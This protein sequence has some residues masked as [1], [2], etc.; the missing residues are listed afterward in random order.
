M[1][2][3]EQAS[4]KPIKTV[5]VLGAGS[6]GTALAIQLARAERPILLWGR[7]GQAIEAMARER[8][9]SRY[10]PGCEFPDNL[11]PVA[12]LSSVLERADDIVL[13]VP[14]HSIRE[15]L[16][17]IAPQLT[18]QRLACAAKGLEPGTGRLLDDVFID[19]L[20]EAYPVAFIAG[21]TFAKEVGQ[22]IPTA[23]TVAARDEQVA[24]DFAA[25][26]H[27]HG[28]R[29]YTQT[30]VI[31]V[32]VGGAVKNVLAIGV[33]IADGLG[34]GANT[35]S[36]MITRGLAEMMRLTEALGGQGETMMG[37]AGIGDLVLTC[38][39]NQSRNRRMGL[40]LAKGKTVEQA[41]QEIGQVVEGVRVA[42]E[43]WRLAQ[44][45]Q[46]EMPICEQIY[47]IL[48]E[49][50]PPLMAAR[51]LSDRPQRAELG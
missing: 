9:N 37:L 23:V 10:L 2:H 5:A 12:D 29:A 34:A 19:I 35:R 48:H 22:G 24:R 31:G 36:L 50:Q 32:E 27:H 25:Y 28:F 11:E 47:R 41:Q 1:D 40:A 26:F 3:Q 39:D 18:G 13:A 21:P 38:T 15:M 20:G 51:V 16:E 49:G 46:V 33:G 44:Q 45:H 7:D 42:A 14:S 17:T 30:D 4:P 6:Y 8:E 43:V